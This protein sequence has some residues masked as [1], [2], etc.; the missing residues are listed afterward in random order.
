MCRESRRAVGR[1]PLSAY[2]RAIGDSISTQSAGMGG[3]PA[4]WISTDWSSVR[5]DGAAT[6][7]VLVENQASTTAKM[8]RNMDE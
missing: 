7:A 2:T 4:T 5:M 8:M 3:G 1:S 6:E